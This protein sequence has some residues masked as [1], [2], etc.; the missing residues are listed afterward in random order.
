MNESAAKKALKEVKEVL[1]TNGI[2]F[3][4]N[5][6][7]LLGAVREGK[8]IEHDDDIELNAWSHKVTEEQMKSVC[9]TLSK[10]GFNTYYSTLSEYICIEK[11]GIPI[12][13]SCFKLLKDIAIRPHEN[14]HGV[15]S[16][17]YIA[18]FFYYLS[19]IFARKWVGKI[20]FS[21]TTRIRTVMIFVLLKI[22]GLLSIRI[23]RKMA[24]FFKDISMR[25]YNDHGIFII[26]AEYYCKLQEIKFY[27]DLYKIPNKVKEYLE[28]L[29]GQNWE[30]PMK[31]WHYY[32]SDK[33]SASYVKYDNDIS[34]FF[35]CNSE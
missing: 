15:G 7:G 10:Q 5:F 32:H 29:Y 31:N 3:W 8:F 2:E 19:E 23:K 12:C 9:R 4:L 26:P 18:R 34:L 1:D 33:K 22:N 25:F 6:G 20:N 16:R 21:R 13:F 11:Y 35:K 30:I 14:V 24:L 17:L 28:Y 27:N